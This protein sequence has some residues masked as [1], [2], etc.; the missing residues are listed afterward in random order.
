MKNIESTA[1]DI[2]EKL[3]K[4]DFFYKHKNLL[5]CGENADGKTTLIKGIVRKCRDKSINVYYINPLNRQICDP[6]NDAVLKKLDKLTIEK[7]V[8][9]RLETNQDIFEKRIS[10]PIVVYN[11]IYDNIEKYNNL[12]WDF[13]GITIASE[14]NE[15]ETVNM[16]EIIVNNKTEIYEVASSQAA[17]MRILLEI[18]YA[19]GKGVKAIVIDEFDEFL[20]DNTTAKFLNKLIEYY[21]NIMFIVSVQALQVILQLDDFDVALICNSGTDSVKDNKVRFYDSSSISEIG[22]IDKLGELLGRVDQVNEL[23]EL[24]ARVVDT[25][26]Y[27]SADIEFIG[28]IERHSLSGREKILFDYVSRMMML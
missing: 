1:K 6:D 7:I 23:E 20:S 10:G 21:E 5:I 26:K 13:F 17:R 2:E 22:H 12:Y 18:D 27:N 8:S 16:P 25:G 28:A 9:D 3:E 4:G 19:V 24:V 14:D 11:E 15:S